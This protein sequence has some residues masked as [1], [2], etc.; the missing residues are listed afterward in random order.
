L[1]H[2]IGAAAWDH[3]PLLEELANQVGQ[4]LGAADGVIVFDP[5]GFVKKGTA[6][7]G[8]QRQW[9]GRVGKIDNGQV[10]VYMGYVSRQEHTL[11]DGRLY[12]PQEW[13]TD[14]KRRRRAGVPRDVRFQTRHALAL[15]MLDR[16]ESRLPH[17]WIAGDDEMGRSTRFR[18]DLQARGQ[19]YL[20]AVPS[21]TLICDLDGPVPPYGGRGARPKPK[22]TRVDAWR[23]ALPSR[24]WTRLKVR[25]GDKGPLTVDIAMTRV[26]AKTDERRAGPEEVLVMIRS[27]DENGAWKNDYYLSNA[28]ADT[29]PAEFARVANAEHRIEACIQR[30][31][32]EA[33]LADYEVRTWRGW[34]HH[35]TLSLLAL[36][37]LVQETRREKKCDARDDA[38]ASAHV[39]GPPA[40]SQPHEPGAAAHRPRMYDPVAA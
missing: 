6:S 38:A 11:V 16:H 30:A 5:S 9:I 23:A 34:Y 36:W 20:L 18:R 7:V 40:R 24:A 12:L 13:A 26:Q 10:G 37:F 19:R 35:Q 32:G 39:A 21:N 3:E 29:P 33:G 28:A 27:R 15:T 31:K 8:V 1:Q 4:V 14:R 22:W 2:F 17:A 25:D